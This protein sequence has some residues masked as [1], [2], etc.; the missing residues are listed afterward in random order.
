[1]LRYLHNALTI[2]QNDR[3]RDDHLLI[4]P[5]RP[6]ELHPEPPTDPDVNLAIHPARATQRTLPPSSKTRSSSGCPLLRSRAPLVGASLLSTSWLIHSI[7]CSA[8]PSSNRF[9]DHS[10]VNSTKSSTY[11]ATFNVFPAFGG[12]GSS[13]D[14][15]GTSYES[16]YRPEQNKKRYSECPLL[17]SA[18]CLRSRKAIDGGSAEGVSR[19]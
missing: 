6:G 8:M 11:G 3:G 16:R 7:A 9:G 4:T 2:G 13:A 19:G 10:Q 5:G 14:E 15:L 17:P 1:V 12:S 18:A